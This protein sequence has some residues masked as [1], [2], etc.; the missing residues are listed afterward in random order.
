[1]QDLLKKTAF[2][3]YPA[4]DFHTIHSI[5]STRWAGSAPIYR[6][7]KLRAAVNDKRLRCAFSFFFS[8]NPIWTPSQKPDP[9]HF[10]IG[11]PFISCYLSFDHLIYLFSILRY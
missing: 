4:V 7:P 3:L 10:F 5:P 6:L 8:N 2:E 1:M 9:A 11:S